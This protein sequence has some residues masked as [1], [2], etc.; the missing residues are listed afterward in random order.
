[1][2]CCQGHMSI[3]LKLLINHFSKYLSLSSSKRKPELPK[4]GVR[5]LDIFLEVNSKEEDY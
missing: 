3:S 2:K 5:N 1:M 4:E